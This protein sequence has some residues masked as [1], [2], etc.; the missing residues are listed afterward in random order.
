M[1]P[2][3]LG[4]R[5][6]VGSAI[7]R[8]IGYTPSEFAKRIDL[9]SR[10]AV[11]ALFANEGY[12]HVYLCAARVGGIKANSERPADFIF[13][14]L[15]IQTNVIDAA[16]HA[17]VEKLLFLGSSCIYPRMAAQPI[18]ENALMTGPLEPTNSAYAVAKIAGIEMCQAYR[19]QYG[20]NAICAM[21]T[22][23]Y[24]PGDRFTDDGHVIP[25]LMARFHA[26]KVRNEASV[27]V[28]GTGKARRE[29]L[30]V[31]DMADAAV[32]LMDRYNEGEPINV[33]DEADIP[34]EELA[35]LVASTVGYRGHIEFD[36][37]KPDGTPRKMLDCSK[38][39]N[40]GWSPKI[41]LVDGLQSTHEWFL[42]QQVA[43]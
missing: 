7:A 26:A 25:S 17:G 41:Y 37:T 40:L 42:G 36:T 14:N 39:T 23:L 16:Y 24:G 2:L 35:E 22:N 29:F 4:H 12:T 31:D 15:M 9:R 21:P 3:V 11:N 1:K 19:K 10:S 20:F 6:L 30:H 33:G 5:G 8:K 43:A 34:I 32:F 28:W 38:M 18:N 27:T 13:D